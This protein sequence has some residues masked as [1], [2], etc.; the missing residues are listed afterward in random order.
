MYSDNAKTF[1]SASTALRSEFGAACPTWK[2]IAPRAA[3]WGGWWE[4]LVRTV[5]SSLRKTLG[6][7][8]LHKVELETCLAEVEA[9]VNSRPLTFVGDEPDS[10][11]PLTP[12][13]FLSG[14][15]AGARLDVSDDAQ[16]VT[17]SMLRE[18][19]LDR[20]NLL[21]RFWAVWQNDYLRS[22]PHAMRKFKSRGRLQVGSVVLVRDD[23]LPRMQW[24]M[25]AVVKVHPGSDG[26][27]RVADV[28][29]AK[30]VRTRA[31]QCLHDLEVLE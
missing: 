5:K 17:A 12:A 13:H 9:C 16:E 8:R 22:L 6:Q 23:H 18:R 21:A 30:G 20:Q 26:V 29:T 24:Q 11:F 7:N 14:R 2:F 31:V 25:G 1:V 10:C 3:W 19:E 27:V 15:L 4:R 28:R